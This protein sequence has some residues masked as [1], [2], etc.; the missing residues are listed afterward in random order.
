MEEQPHGCKDIANFNWSNYEV[1]QCEHDEHNAAIYTGPLC[2]TCTKGY[3]Q[4]DALSCEPCL[5]TKDGRQVNGGGIAAMIAAYGML[6]VGYILVTSWFALLEEGEAS[7]AA[8]ACAVGSSS[9]FWFAELDFTAVSKAFIMYL[10]YMFGTIF[11]V[12]VSWPDSL[13]KIMK[14]VNRLWQASNGASASLD[15]LLQDLSFLGDSNDVTRTGLKLLINL[16]GCALTYLA[17]VFMHCL[18]SWLWAKYVGQVLAMMSCRL[19]AINFRQKALGMLH[20]HGGS[21][22]DR[23][24]QQDVPISSE[25]GGAAAE[26]NGKGTAFT[27]P[28]SPSKDVHSSS[29]ESSFSGPLAGLRRFIVIAALVSLFFWY[30][31]IARVAI[32]TIACVPICDGTKLWMIDMRHICPHPSATASKSVR[33]WAL[34]VGVPAWIVTATLPVSVVVLLVSAAVKRPSSGERCLLECQWFR[35]YFG[36][37]YSDYQRYPNHDQDAALSRRVSRGSVAESGASVNQ[38][39]SSSS[40]RALSPTSQAKEDFLCHVSTLDGATM[41]SPT[42]HQA[43]WEP[44]AEEGLHK[45]ATTE[46]TAEAGSGSC[47]RRPVALLLRSRTE[48]LFRFLQTWGT[49]FKH[50]L[51]LVWD[52]VIHLHSFILVVLSILGMRLHEYYQLLLLCATLGS[53]LMLIIW[54]RPFKAGSQQLQ[55][56]SVC[57]VFWTSSLSLTFVQPS[58]VSEAEAQDKSGLMNKME[59]AAAHLIIAGNALYLLFIVVCMLAAG[60]YTKP[61]KLLSR[62]ADAGEGHKKVA[63]SV[64]SS[65]SSSVRAELGMQGSQSSL[66][67]QYSCLED[68]RPSAD[69][70]GLHQR[71]PKSSQQAVGP[72]GEL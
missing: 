37:M 17:V 70:S 44:D 34:A 19:W 41:D 50:G 1:N 57:V 51:P 11:K 36:F 35:G 59:D 14:P 25:G 45:T 23:R 4:T 33:V 58:G 53:Y 69:Q 12:P 6:F 7:G 61:F 22:V 10:Q 56:L 15:C 66:K 65:I 26:S 72:N 3:G 62:I 38:V 52:A 49:R 71:V 31:T 43:H 28:A 27:V 67:S 9:R 68:V 48:G 32:S 60:I 30:P 63:G 46:L 18:L 16:L 64:Q 29:S 39:S 54:I 13:T 47:S 55:T 42:P 5:K 2:G 24:L 21:H 8:A 20:V 40:S